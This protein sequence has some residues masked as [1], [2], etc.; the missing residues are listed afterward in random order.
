M[1]IS[2][3]VGV[4]SIALDPDLFWSDEFEWASTE[5]SISR[6]C[7]G[8]MIIHVGS[9]IGGRPITL[10]PEDSNSGWM[11]R[12]DMAQIQGWANTPG[13]VMT[14]TIRGTAYPVMFRHHDG[15]PFEARPVVHYA[16][17]ENTDWLLLTLKF[18]TL[19]G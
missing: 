15:S 12:A 11:T 1:T 5:Q 18:I 10:Q 6:S 17:P 16:D 9:R 2:L 8:A 7:T 14:L 19:P 13:Q 4:T 3:A